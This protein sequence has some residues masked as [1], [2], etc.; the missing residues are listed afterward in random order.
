MIGIGEN[1]AHC[2]LCGAELEIDEDPEICDDCQEQ[3]QED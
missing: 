1:L 3:L 2:L